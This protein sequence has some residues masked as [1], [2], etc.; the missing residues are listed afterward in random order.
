MRK[1][2]FLKV[3]QA[4]LPW[5]FATKTHF[6]RTVDCLRMSESLGSS[7]FLASFPVKKKQQFSYVSK[8]AFTVYL[9]K[10]K[11][12]LIL[13]LPEMCRCLEDAALPQHSKLSQEFSKLSVSSEHQDRATIFVLLSWQSPRFSSEFSKPLVFRDGCSICSNPPRWLPHPRAKAVL[14]NALHHLTKL[15]FD[16]G[17][18]SNFH[19]GWIGLLSRYLGHK[20]ILKLLGDSKVI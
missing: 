16:L 11:N 13:R 9:S 2:V 8:N 20:N 3:L 4:I 14:L 15:R 17:E 12:V 7:A 6:V 10:K 5:G 18:G 1:H 19:L